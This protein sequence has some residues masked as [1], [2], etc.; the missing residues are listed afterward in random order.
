ML[1]LLSHKDKLLVDHLRQV[2][3]IA[4]QLIGG[5]GYHFTFTNGAE[6]SNQHLDDLV[7]IAGAFHDLAKATRYFQDYIRNPE[8]VHNNLKNHASLSSI[9]VWFVVK[10]YCE[11]EF[12]DK[13]LTDLIPSLLL[14][15][16]KR[17]HGSVDN[18]ETELSFSNE[19][20]GYCTEQINSIDD[21]S[22]EFVI[23]ELITET[24]IKTT[25]KE[26][27]EYWQS[28]E[29]KFQ[30][31]D[32]KMLIFKFEY[33]KYE[34]SDRLALFNLFQI[35]YSALMYSDKNDVILENN[36]FFQ[37]KTDITFCINQFRE[38]NGF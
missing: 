18:F 16:V 13:F 23:S 29:F 14:I 10:G 2:A 35:V 9:F 11:K 30:I 20:I 17:H 6:V 4:M 27:K 31:N 25:W 3:N 5:K 15:A 12:T 32:F 21:K 38:K 24:R 7:W 8:A 22:V 19:S 33:P 1:E 34:E 37:G 26:F 28:D 36:L